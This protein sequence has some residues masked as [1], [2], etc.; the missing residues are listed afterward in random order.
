MKMKRRFFPLV[1][2]SLFMISGAQAAWILSPTNSYTTGG[3]TIELMAKIENNQV[4]FT[5]ARKDGNP[6]QSDGVMTIR[7]GSNSSEYYGCVAN[8]SYSKP[9]TPSQGTIQYDKDSFY[10]VYK[11]GQTSTTGTFPLSTYRDLGLSKYWFAA[12]GAPGLDERTLKRDRGVTSIP[13]FFPVSGKPCDNNPPE[14]YSGPISLNFELP[15]NLPKSAEF[16]GA[17]SLIKPEMS[18][19]G[20]DKDDA[21][22]HPSD[23]QTNSSTV[24]FQTKNTGICQKYVNISS[25]NPK[26]G[27][28][29]VSVRKWNDPQ[30]IHTYL[31][32][33]LPVSVPVVGNY[34]VIAVTTLDHLNPNDSSKIFAPKAPGSTTIRAE[35]SSSDANRAGRVEIPESLD[36][37]FSNGYTWAGNGSVISGKTGSCAED[38]C[39]QDF[40]IA[41]LASDNQPPVPALTAFQWLVSDDCKTLH[42]QAVDRDGRAINGNGNFSGSLKYKVWYSKTWTDRGSFSSAQDIILSKQDYYVVAIET[43]AEAISSDHRIKASCATS[44]SS[45]SSSSSTTSGSYGTLGTGSY[46]NQ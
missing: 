11:K 3:N 41:S 15:P 23:T 36:V 2:L 6:F 28:V 25:D 12:I 45:T 32:A 22:M 4:T 19:F 20:C 8:L 34:S 1:F 38:G 40:A 33:K 7:A 42:I 44:Q 29:L 18:C 30:L 9:Y 24:V 26:I 43:G 35:C 46:Y 13:P 5:V 37:L 17:G 16:Q 10:W 27:Q 14:T 39:T 21:T 31:A